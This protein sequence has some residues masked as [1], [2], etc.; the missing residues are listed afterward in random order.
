MNEFELIKKYF[1]S[2]SKNSYSSLNLNDDVFFDK[3]KRL[4]V[5]VDTYIEG[6]HFINFRKPGLVIK[7]IVRSSISDLVCKGVFPKYY[8][9]SGSGNKKNFTKLNLSLVRKSLVDEQ[10]KYNIY[11]S[12][13]D[14]VYSNKLSFTITS[15]GFAKNIESLGSTG[16]PFIQGTNFSIVLPQLTALLL[17]WASFLILFSSLNFQIPSIISAFFLEI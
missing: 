7:K 3:K 9:I 6:K 13:G 5:S 16:N 10:K 15:I 1:L 11:L 8:F 14:T 2:L 12:G 17:E 4:V